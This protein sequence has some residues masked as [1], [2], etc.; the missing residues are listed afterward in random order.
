MEKL[1]Q[2]SA[3]LNEMY[4]LN[5]KD[6]LNLSNLKNKGDTSLVIDNPGA[7]QLRVSRNQSLFS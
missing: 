4:A 6:Y 7:S 3:H 1:G 2:I 5:M